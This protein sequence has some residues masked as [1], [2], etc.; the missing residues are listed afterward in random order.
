MTMVR[1]AY[2][3][4]GWYNACAADIFDGDLED[5]MTIKVNDEEFDK[6]TPGIDYLGIGYDSISG[7]TLGGEESL[8]DP[9]YRAP[10]I[11]FSWRKSAEGYSPSLNA[12]QEIENLEELKS[13]FAASAE[14]KGDVSAAS[15]SASAKYKK[16]AANL[17]H[18]TERM[19]LHCDTCIRYQ[20]G[21]PLNI[22]WDT[23]E[24]FKEA[25]KILQPLDE[26][27]KKECSM[28]DILDETTKE[29]CV[30]L[31]KWIKFFQMFGTHYVHQLLLGGKLIQTLKID[32]NKFQELKKQGIDVDLAV[33][34]ILG[35][36]SAS[37][38]GNDILNQHKFDEIGVKTIT[39]IGGEMPNT[40][41]T[42][43]E[44]ATWGNS[45]ADN[46]MPIGISAD[47]LK[48][49]LDEKLRDSYTLAL[50]KY[51]ELNGVTYETLVRL[52]ASVGGLMREIKNGEGIVTVNWDFNGAECPKGQKIL[53]GFSL[54]FNKHGTFLGI[55]PCKTGAYKCNVPLNKQEIRSV[56]WA[57]CTTG[58]QP[59]I[60]QVAD[61]TQDRADSVEASCPYGTIIH[62][63]IKFYANVERLCGIESCI[64]GESSCKA[65]AKGG[66]IAGIWIVCS[67]DIRP[68]D[69]IDVVGHVSKENVKVE[70]DTNE[71]IIGG[72][73]VLF[74]FHKDAKEDGKRSMSISM[75]NQYLDYCEV[76]CE[77]NCLAALVLAICSNTG[78]KSSS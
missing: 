57:T 65:T 29:N 51:A 14:L 62:F 49:F 13:A 35:S 45:V 74:K 33:S 77:G 28:H 44:Y 67:T 73:K 21:I 70:C 20:A 16:E 46:P 78:T 25:V 34:S 37:V 68:G 8:L 52:G 41:I 11:N 47:S 30:P 42:D 63:G 36:A 10:I 50:Y 54:L 40:P 4:L 18:K 71:I 43:A 27:V 66:E 24:S 3:I 56:S 31:K 22:P 19:Y 7:N 5:L 17:A 58:L 72:I 38:E 9:G 12:I 23:T 48:K 26:T 64:K 1:Q 60:Y 6:G 59:T 69:Q 76:K 55:I 39:V 75:C 53:I 2:F 61:I 32:M 15:F